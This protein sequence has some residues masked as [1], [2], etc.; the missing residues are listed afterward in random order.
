[1][2]GGEADPTK[3]IHGSTKGGYVNK[4]GYRVISVSGKPQLEHRVVMEKVLGR[5]LLR[6]ETIHHKDGDRL[7]NVPENLE[8]H[9]GNHGPGQDIQDRIRAAQ[10]LLDNYGH[11]LR[12]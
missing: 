3:W 12:E 10:E 6:E 4:Y 2:G 8:L 5:V 11:L 1:M 7:N 9:L